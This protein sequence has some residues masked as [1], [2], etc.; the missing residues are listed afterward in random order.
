MTALV[1]RGGDGWFR[2]YVQQE[3]GHYVAEAVLD[4]LAGLEENRDQRD[5]LP[6]ADVAAAAA[7]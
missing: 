1:L 3:L 5:L 6:E 4:A 2:V 7:S